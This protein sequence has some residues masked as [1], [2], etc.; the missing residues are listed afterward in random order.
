MQ[1]NSIQ[2][3]NH[4]AVSRSRL[5]RR[6][7]L[8]GL[9]AALAGSLL[10]ACAPA[11]ARPAATGAAANRPLRLLPSPQPPADEGATFGTVDAQSLAQFLALSVLLTGITPLDPIVGRVYLEHLQRTKAEGLVQLYQQAGFTETAAPTTLQA[12]EAAG[13]FTTAALRQ[14]ADQIIELW[15]TGQIKREAE[16]GQAETVVVT[17]VDALAWKALDF[18]K[19]PTICAAPYVWATQPTMTAD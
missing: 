19:P 5:S 8:L 18:T 17:F 6:T 11:S 14:L 3:S 1:A 9:P 15:Y 13:I 12:L 10:A 2:P 7:L 4:R 16:A